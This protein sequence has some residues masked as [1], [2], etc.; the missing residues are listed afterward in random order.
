MI[1][2]AESEMKKLTGNNIRSDQKLWVGARN[3]CNLRRSN[4][5]YKKNPRKGKDQKTNLCNLWENIKCLANVKSSKRKRGN[6]KRNN[7]IFEEI[8]F[9]YF[10]NLIKIMNPQIHECQ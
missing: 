8:I 2:N 10:P 9:K 7:N 1:R 3:Q 6:K 4:N 5:N